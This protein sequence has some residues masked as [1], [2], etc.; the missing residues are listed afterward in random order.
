VPRAEGRILRPGINVAGSRLLFSAELVELRPCSSAWKPKRVAPK[1]L[2][3]IFL[4]KRR[5][6]RIWSDTTRGLDAG[7][8]NKNKKWMA[9]NFFSKSHPS[10]HAQC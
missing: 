1:E 2:M 9:A 6:S 3:L 8:P 5:A 10:R 4:Q 7:R